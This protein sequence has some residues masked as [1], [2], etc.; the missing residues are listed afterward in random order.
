MGLLL[1]GSALALLLIGVFSKKLTKKLVNTFINI[2]KFFKLKNVDRKK[3]RIEEGLEQYNESA[4]YIKSHKE[5]FIKAILRVFLQI[6][7]Y[8]S[9]PF[10]VYKAFGLSGNNFFQ[11]FTMQAVLYTTVSGIPL[12]GA[13]GISETVFLG[14]FGVAF[15]E[16]LLHAS[17]LLSRGI[18]F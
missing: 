14:I 8:Y 5:E 7:F 15:G 11:I 2:L 12:P 18:T 17:M 1:N 6:G 16:E 4:I 3:D 9:V 13:I 10:C